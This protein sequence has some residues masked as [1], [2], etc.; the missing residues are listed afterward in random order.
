MLHCST[1]M[2]RA[3]TV[4]QLDNGLF[5]YLGLGVLFVFYYLFYVRLSVPVQLI[6]P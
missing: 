3:C 6:E 1:I 2:H 5:L 4:V